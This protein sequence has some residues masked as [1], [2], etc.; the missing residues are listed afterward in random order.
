MDKIQRIQALTKELNQYRNEYYNFN[1]SSVSDSTYDS[2]FDELH[3]LESQSGYILA[4]SPTQTV[5]YEVVSKLQKVTHITALKSLDKTKSIDEL[6]K[7]RNGKDIILMLKADGLTIEL[8]YDNGNLIEASTRGNGEIGEIVTHNAKTFKNIPLTIPFKGK[9]RLAGEAIIHKNDFDEINSKLSEDEKYATPRNLVAGS[10]RQLDGK[11]CAERNVYFYAF[12]ILECSEELSDSK[13]NNFAWLWEQGFWTIFSLKLSED[14]TQRNIEIM[15]N[16]AKEINLP[17]DGEVVSFDS[18]KYSNSLTETAHHPLHSFAYKF[19]DDL[20]ET[21]LRDVEWNTTRTGQITPTGI[22]DTV[23]IDGTEVSRA[24]LHNLSFIE[25]LELDI[26]CR[27]LVSKRNLII[28]HIEDNLDK[29]GRLMYIPEK[30]PSCG[31]NT[32]TKN[33]GTADFLFCTNNN[34]PAQQLDRFVNFVK[35]DSMNIEGLSEATLEKF[36]DMG[37]IK[38]FADIYKLDKYKSQIIRT[39]G[40]GIR[41]YEKLIEAIE[42]SKEVKMQNFLVALGIN[43]IGEGGAKRLAKHF[44][45]DINKFLEATKSHHN[46]TGIEDFGLITAYAVY[47]YFNNESNMSQVKEL[48][49]YVSVK[50]EGEKKTTVVS[51]NPFKGAKVYATGKFANYK[52]EDIKKVLEDLGAEFAGGYAKSLNYLIVGSIEGSSKEDKAKKDGVPILSE[53][54][55]IKM[56]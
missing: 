30:C 31:Y 55:F 27:I 15:V 9:L 46:F 40:F 33:T 11:I 17:I 50:Q 43:Q 35:R 3:T 45:N 41:S 10:V 5:G 25:G 36:I 22:F 1:K 7:W 14:I 2:L 19:F 53:E 8:D 16:Y 29:D 32:Y 23:I 37:W 56:I 51:D 26:G 38:T 47:E 4:N 20:S 18:V 6:N 12:N 48:L 24:S 39:E 44:K 34:C 13:H 28:P 49:E 42:K 54:E 52:K 21:V